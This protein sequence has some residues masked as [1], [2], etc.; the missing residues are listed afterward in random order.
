MIP[1]PKEQFQ[2]KICDLIMLFITQ[3]Q[4][5]LSTETHPSNALKT[6]SCLANRCLPLW[7]HD[8]T[9]SVNTLALDNEEFLP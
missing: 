4:P 6:S 5:S 2:M 7:S 8:T 3:A 9:S 1:S